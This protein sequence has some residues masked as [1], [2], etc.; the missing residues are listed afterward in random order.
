MQLALFLV[1]AV[2]GP[3]GE[4]LLPLAVEDL[5]DQHWRVMDG[6]RVCG[7][8]ALKKRLKH[9]AVVLLVFF[10]YCY[11]WSDIYT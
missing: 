7:V 5:R 10:V 8:L 3:Q 6:S 9:M 1:A 11:G 2:A 4:L